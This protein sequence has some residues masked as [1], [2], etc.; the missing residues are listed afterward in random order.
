MKTKTRPVKVPEFPFKKGSVP[1][2]RGSI[3]I[4]G[5]VKEHPG[6]TAWRR[7]YKDI[8]G[9]VR[10]HPDKPICRVLK[11]P[12]QIIYFSYWRLSR[13][14]CFSWVT[15]ADKVPAGATVYNTYKEWQIASGRSC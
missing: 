11:A 3:S 5:I 2:R 8:A 15:R 10:A 13:V 4:R 1:D 14:T 9:Y 6:H 7:K 12:K